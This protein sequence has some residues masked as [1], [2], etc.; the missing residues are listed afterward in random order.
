[1]GGG[2]GTSGLVAALIASAYG[3]TPD[4]PVSLSRA[5]CSSR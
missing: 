1:M 4:D 3:A 2:E 5:A